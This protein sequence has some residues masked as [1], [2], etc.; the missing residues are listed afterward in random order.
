[1]EAVIRW[2]FG[3]MV[4]AAWS[5]ANLIFTIKI[6]KISTLSKD[7]GRLSALIMLKFP[8]L[9]LIGFLILISKAFPIPSLLTGMTAVLITTGISRLWLTRA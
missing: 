8:V 3:L 7:P 9:Y 2:S 4:G 1:M 6:L 5:A